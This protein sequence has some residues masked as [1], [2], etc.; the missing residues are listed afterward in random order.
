MGLAAWPNATLEP[1]RL[2]FPRLLADMNY[3]GCKRK[4][5]IDKYVAKVNAAIRK[6]NSGGGAGTSNSTMHKYLQ[7]K[8]EAGDK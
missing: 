3:A 1:H 6:L 2:I 8:R 5:K 4:F 7:P